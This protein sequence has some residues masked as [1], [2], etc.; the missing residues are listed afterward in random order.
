M[1]SS[2]LNGESKTAGIK[3]GE[4]PIQESFLIVDAILSSSDVDALRKS[5]RPLSFSLEADEAWTKTPL[6]QSYLNY[7]GINF[8]DTIPGIRQAF[9]SFESGDFS[10]AAHY[11]LPAQSRGTIF[12]FHGYYDHVGLYHHLIRFALKN[13]YAVVAYDLPGMGLSSGERASIQSF[14]DYYRALNKC[15]ELFRGVVPEPWH[16]VGQSAG[17]AALLNHLLAEGLAPFQKMALLAPLVRSKGW[18][19]HRW[20]H[21]IGKI[22]I[23][24]LPRVFTINSHDQDFLDFLKHA[25]PLQPRHLS[26]A[27]V[28][29]MKEWISRFEAFAPRQEAVLVIQGDDD[30]TVDWRHNVE[31]IRSKL[32]AARIKVISQARH[33][34]VAESAPYREQVF[35]AIK[36]YLEQ[37]DD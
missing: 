30:D 19:R 33:H 9:G 32:P 35:A 24:R 36:S 21:A 5:L 4:S 10:I 12:V 37:E 3:V 27:W 11:W 15:C 6:V 8:A 22:F 26:V 20:I 29:A 31:R 14:E 13:G 7:Y 2:W 28:S 18:P 1:N 17:C 25:D 16:A 34:L 23:R